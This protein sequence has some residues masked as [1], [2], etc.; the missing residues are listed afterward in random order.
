MAFLRQLT[1]EFAFSP[2]ALK[3]PNI[4]IPAARKR[5]PE[6][7]KGGKPVNPKETAR[8]VIPHMT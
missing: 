5:K 2:F 3:Y 7:I 4:M 8:N 1:K 6:R